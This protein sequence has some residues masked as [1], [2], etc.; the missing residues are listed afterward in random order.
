MLLIAI[1]WPVAALNVTLTELDVFSLDLLQVFQGQDLRFNVSKP[2]P[3]SGEAVLKDRRS[4]SMQV[5]SIP[6]PYN[7]PGYQPLTNGSFVCLDSQCVTFGGNLVKVFIDNKLVWA[8]EVTGTVEAATLFQQD[9]FFVCASVAEPQRHIVIWQLPTGHP[10]IYIGEELQSLQE[11]HLRGNSAGL[12]VF[13]SSE[14]FVYNFDS[15]SCSL[16]TG[17]LVPGL[18]AIVEVQ[19]YEDSFLVLD[20]LAGLVEL[21]PAGL[22]VFIS[23][24]GKVEGTFLGC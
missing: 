2:P 17:Q 4:T 21:E 9:V 11:I 15:P 16:S 7:G 19:P 1:L 22:L 18:E 14:V 6:S 20:Q 12:I 13:S 23:D 5:L 8:G 10:V 24:R 3:G